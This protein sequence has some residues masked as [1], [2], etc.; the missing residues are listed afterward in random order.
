M[1][2]FNVD[3]SNGDD[4]VK[5]SARALDYLGM[6]ARRGGLNGT[7]VP[8]RQEAGEPIDWSQL[9]GE[10]PIR[11]WWIPQ[12]LT[13]APTLLAGAGGC[14]KSLLLQTLCTSL[15]TGRPYLASVEKPLTCMIWSC[16]DDRDEIWRRQDRINDHFKITK[17]DLSRLLI[18]PRV[19]MDNTLLQLRFGQPVFTPLLEMLRRQVQRFKPDVLVLDN[20]AHLYGGIV[21]G[22][23]VTEFINA[24]A[25]LVT[26]RPF[27]PILVGHVAR[28]QG[29]EFSGHAAWENGVRV[30]CFI[31][32]G[33]SGGPTLLKVGKTNYSA[34]TFVRFNYSDGLLVPENE[35]S[36]AD[37]TRRI[38]GAKQVLQAALDTLCQRS[39]KASHVSASSNYLPRLLASK[40]VSLAGGFS[41]KELAAALSQLDLAGQL[42][43][44]ELKGANGRKTE[45]LADIVL[46]PADLP[47]ER[48]A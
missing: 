21:D 31:E 15:A 29:S 3:C 36:S 34:K 18:V 19:G 23:Q 14:G 41:Q 7:P 33:E 24:I 45:V 30:R 1:S 37:Q 40:Y 10:A 32:P 2:K 6:S 8:I 16:E 22:H 38:A 4:K 25:G 12:F 42:V 5:D 13:P 17:R 28:T 11:T 35:R 46:A 27:A 43:K 44:R 9:D 48:A 20:I 39:I 47:F 26:D